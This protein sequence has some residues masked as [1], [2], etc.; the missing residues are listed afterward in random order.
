MMGMLFVVMGSICHLDVCVIWCGT[1]KEA[2]PPPYHHAHQL[3]GVREPEAV[4]PAITTTAYNSMPN[5]TFSSRLLAKVM[6][7]KKITYGR[8]L[9]SQCCDSRTNNFH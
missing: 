6:L 8:H 9:I 7:P 2:D 5:Q 4:V 1:G 3:T